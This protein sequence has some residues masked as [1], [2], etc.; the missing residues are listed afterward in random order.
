MRTVFGAVA[1]ALAVGAVLVA[2]DLGVHQTFNQ[3][4]YQSGSP[5]AVQA[6]QTGYA[7]PYAPYAVSYAAP[8]G[9]PFAAP[10]PNGVAAPMAPVAGYAVPQYVSQPVVTAQAPVRRYASQQTYVTDRARTPTRSW[11]KSAL[12]IAGSAAG[13]AGVGGLI[14]GKKG[15]GIGALLGGGTAALFDQIKRN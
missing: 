15:A 4:G 11:Q 3:T 10:Y 6:G 14:G 13:G 5:Y 8:Y 2:Y 1:G 9:A 7:S 12:L